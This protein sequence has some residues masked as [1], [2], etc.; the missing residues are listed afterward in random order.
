M[1]KKKLFIGNLPWSIDS[2]QLKEIFSKFGSIVEA[3]VITER[4][5]GRS[6][7]FGFVEFET[8]EAAQKAIDEL[9]EKEIEGRKIFVNVAKPKSEE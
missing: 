5:S 8:E 3:V 7:G 9:N 6:K 2:E 1:N 4:H